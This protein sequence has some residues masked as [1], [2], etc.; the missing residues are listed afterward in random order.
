MRL[1]SSVRYRG[2]RSPHGF[3][4][5]ELLVVIAIIG[6][7]V[8][9][10]LPAVNGAREAGR[11]TVCTNN[12]YQIALACTQF[13][14]ANGFLPGW[15]NRLTT[16][17]NVSW[18]VMVLP[19]ME[20]KDIYNAL[21]SGAA[22]SPYISFF[23]CPSSP[24]DATTSPWLAY[25]GNC[26]SGGSGAAGKADGVM[27]DATQAS[28]NLNSLDD[29]VDGTATTLLLSEKCGAA[30]TTP[31]TWN[32]PPPASVN[33]N[34][35]EI[36]PGF[37]VTG[38]PPARI[39]NAG[40]VH[41]APGTRSQPSSQHPGGAVAAFCDGRTLFLKDSLQA[42]VYAQLITSNNAS[43]SGFI[44]GAGSSQWGTGTYIL[45]EGDFQ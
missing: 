14:D 5:V 45:S 17:S 35:G 25:A 7:L 41:A 13:N 4:L 2:S 24:P 27:V 10:L 16:T 37:G 40:N 9:L 39:L 11:R 26:G 28:T 1:N 18:S 6:V 21:I 8:G 3:T 43:A 42:R 12:Q 31:M 19:F 30:Y 44:T 15:R 36:F 22:A 33:W 29:I 20:R 34:N 23:V 32:V 38:T